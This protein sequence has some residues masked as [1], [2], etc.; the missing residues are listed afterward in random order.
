M[1]S[2]I[3]SKTATVAHLRYGNGYMISS[4]TWMGVMT[5]MLESKLIH[6]SE[7]RHGPQSMSLTMLSRCLLV[8]C[9]L[10]PQLKNSHFY[11]TALKGSGVLSSPERAG[12]W[13]A[14][15]TSPV[16]TLTSIIFHGSFSN[17]ARHLSPQDLGRVWSWRFCL[18]KYAHSG[19]FN[20][21]ASFGIPG[22]L[23]Q[24]KVTKLGANVGL[25]NIYCGFGNFFYAFSNFAH[26]KS[27]LA[28]S[29][30]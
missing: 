2:F 23:F 17:L 24:A 27:P 30:P 16:N 28:L 20:E 7:R 12:G 14:G 6:V 21:P 13:A 11:P 26:G 3:H 19:P 29:R 18:I 15:H 8:F 10:H 5:P 25:I 22:P 4:Y 9:I 1:R